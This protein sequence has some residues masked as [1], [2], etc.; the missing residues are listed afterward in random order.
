MGMWLAWAGGHLPRVDTVLLKNT[1]TICD[2]DLP[3]CVI[4][5]T[6][7]SSR[8]VPE[9]RR[10]ARLFAIMVRRSVGGCHYHSPNID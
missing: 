4:V 10:Q 3:A 2:V 8:T 7:Y 5:R 6:I 9:K 1:E